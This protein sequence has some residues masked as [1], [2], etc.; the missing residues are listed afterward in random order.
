[1]LPESLSKF[2]IPVEVP[3]M[4]TVVVSGSRSSDSC[5]GTGRLKQRSADFVEVTK[6][7]SW[8][9]LIGVDMVEL[10]ERVQPTM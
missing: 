3:V 9:S 4:Y 5:A 8:D 2:G 1:M 7:K 6:P 10:I